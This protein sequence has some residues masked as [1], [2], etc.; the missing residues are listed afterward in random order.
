M[1]KT[2]LYRTLLYLALTFYIVYYVMTRYYPYTPYPLNYILYATLLLYVIGVYRLNPVYCSLSIIIPYI[3]LLPFNVR[4]NQYILAGGII[5]FYTSEYLTTLY[6]KRSRHSKTLFKYISIPLLFSAILSIIGLNITIAY[7]VS[8]MVLNAVEYVYSTTPS[9]F[10]A[11]YDITLGSR[12]GLIL[13]VVVTSM[14]IVYIIDEYIYGFITEILSFTRRTA[15][16]LINSIVEREFT[17]ILGFKDW[18]NTLYLRIIMFIIMFYTYGLLYPVTSFILYTLIPQYFKSLYN[19]L[20]KYPILALI[21]HMVF[22]IIISTTLYV[23]IKNRFL[24]WMKPGDIEDYI[25]DLSLKHRSFYLTLAL[26]VFYIVFLI[27]NTG[28]NTYYVFLKVFYPNTSI[29]TQVNSVDRLFSTMI[30]RYIDPLPDW[31]EQYF[32]H[33]TKSYIEL[34]NL[35]ENLIK[36]IWG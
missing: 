31:I 19:L 15:F 36:F 22:T 14:I 23:W 28:F 11:V 4:M 33:V 24:K 34:S 5:W 12:I 30:S 29:T 10:K 9:I 35:L 7:M 32:D 18:F 17:Q 21:L 6:V 25:R 26:T 20:V 1:D 27:L 13:F 8:N 16:T 2:T 3:I